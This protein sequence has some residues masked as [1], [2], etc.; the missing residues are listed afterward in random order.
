[1]GVFVTL[2]G[3]A[4]WSVLGGNLPQVFVHDIVIHPR[5]RMIAIATHGR[6][7]WVLDA[8]PVQGRK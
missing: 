6:G 7:V 5:D 3:G 4:T 1:M 2:D 8:V